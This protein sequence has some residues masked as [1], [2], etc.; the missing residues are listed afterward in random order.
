M[1]Y[2]TAK[3]LTNYTS[4]TTAPSGGWAFNGWA[5]SPTATSWVCNPNASNTSSGS[6][7]LALPQQAAVSG[8]D[9]YGWHNSQTAETPMFLT[10]VASTHTWY[11]DQDDKQNDY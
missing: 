3:A 4:M 8:W 6:V 10:N 9:R 5:T 1:T 2:D 11:R 7:I